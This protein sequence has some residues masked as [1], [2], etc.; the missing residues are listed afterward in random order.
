MLILLPIIIVYLLFEHTYDYLAISRPTSSDI[1]VVE[2]WIPEYGLKKAIDY[3]YKYNY[4]YMVITGVPITQWAFSSPY[5]NMA[6]ASARSMREMYFRDS[7]YTVSIP[8]TIVRDRTYTTAIALKMAM[9]N[10]KIPDKDF[11]L[12][13]VGAHARRSSLMF[14]L[15]FGNYKIGIVADTDISYTPDIWYKTSYGFRIVSSELISY[16]YSSVFFRPNEDEIRSE[17]RIGRDIDLIQKQRFSKDKEFSDS[18]RSPLLKSD[19]Q[20]F[21]GLSY[22]LI[23]EKWKIKAKISIDTSSPIFKM[24]TSTARLPEYRKYALLSFKINDTLHDLTAFQNMDLLKKN[25]Q[26]KY[27]FLPFKDKTNSISSYG[28]GR[29][30]DLEIADNDSV[31]IDFNSAYNPYCA[32]SH[33]WSCPIPPPSNYLNTFVDAGEKKYH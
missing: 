23:Q 15:A 7:I 18:L 1:L 10:G 12:Y 27:L 9:E 16:L 13:T 21:R 19:I 25:P 4:K 30:I 2:G 33:K 14:R 29:F 26:S 32:Y 28:G 6:D 8:S 22:F 24:P 17:I 5:S 3:Y 31:T 20:L 11:D